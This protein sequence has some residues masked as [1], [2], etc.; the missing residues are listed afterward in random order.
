[1]LRCLYTAQAEGSRELAS[2]STV[3]RCA[4]LQGLCALPDSMYVAAAAAA[5]AVL[6]AAPVA[7]ALVAVDDAVAAAAWTQ[8]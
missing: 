8:W 5:V 1:M 3:L 6:S 7:A 2:L 4:V